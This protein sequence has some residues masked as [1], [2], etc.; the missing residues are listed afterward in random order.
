MVTGLGR[1][2]V[3]LEDVP[4]A[5]PE[6]REDEDGGQRDEQEVFGFDVD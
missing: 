1:F 2:Q 3:H 6:P 5:V 4:A